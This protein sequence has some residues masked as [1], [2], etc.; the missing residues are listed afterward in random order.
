MCNPAFVLRVSPRNSE[1]PPQDPQSPSKSG[2]YPPVQSGVIL[3]VDDELYVRQLTGRMLR[4]L[5]YEVLEAT[6]AAEALRILEGP[7]KIR[8]V[9]TDIAM[10]GMD[11]V[12]LADTIAEQHPGHPVLLMSGFAG[13]IR[14]LGFH[15]SPLPILQKPFNAAD[16]DRAVREALE[17]P[18]RPS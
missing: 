7:A 9:L 11:G 18:D 10:P 12:R 17:A 6:T 13:V 5:G 4:D 8:L 3:V 1:P 14:K 15:S 16:L 2:P